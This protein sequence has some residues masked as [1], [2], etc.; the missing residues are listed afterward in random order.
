MNRWSPL[1]LLVCLGMSTRAFAFAPKPDA[2][3]SEA[4]SSAAESD[5]STGDKKA[6]P[7]PP[8]DANSGTD[9]NPDGGSFDAGGPGCSSDQECGSCQVCVSGECKGLGLVVCKVDG[10]CVPGQVCQVNATDACKN[11]C[12]TK[13]SCT[14]DSGC[15][16]CTVCVSGECK[17]LGAVECMT[18]SECGA[19]KVCKTVPG[20]TCKNTCVPAGADAGGSDTSSVDTSS[21]GTDAGGPDAGSTDTASSSDVQASDAPK[22]SDGVSQ[23]ATG[24]ADA[25]S[26]PAGKKADG[27]SAR[28]VGASPWAFLLIAIGV[29]AVRRRLA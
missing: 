14:A 22:A 11:Q 25:G 24:S 10:D 19:G 12:V 2:G 16:A 20:E 23:D 29:V 28:P 7:P 3:S 15:P 27:C 18:D 13:P 21:G 8:E 5:A 4:D 1:V 9:M 6:P 17:G 26:A